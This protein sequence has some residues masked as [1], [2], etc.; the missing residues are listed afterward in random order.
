[1]VGGFVTGGK[2]DVCKCKPVL[3]GGGTEILDNYGTL[4][5]E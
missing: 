2:I 5:V 4:P 3:R 1:V